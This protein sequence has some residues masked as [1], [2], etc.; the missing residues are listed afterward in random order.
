M[1]K[2]EGLYIWVDDLDQAIDFY[3]K[4][5]EKDIVNRE[6]NRWA[7]F[8]DDQPICV[9]LYNYTFDSEK[10]IVGN[11][12]TPELRTMNINEE[13][14]RIKSLNPKSISDII[15]L[16]K[17]VLYKYFQFEDV[18]GNIWEVSEHYYN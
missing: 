10:Q 1:L 4:V 18:W 6:K 15:I 11:N 8:G 14:K 17:P 5:F 2:P 16:E 12:I 3:Q 13:Y 7:D 9:G